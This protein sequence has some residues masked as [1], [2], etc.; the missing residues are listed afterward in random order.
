LAV[1][2]RNLGTVNAWAFIFWCVSSSVWKRLR[3]SD[4]WTCR[5][6]ISCFIY[7]GFDA[8]S[9]KQSSVL[10]VICHSDRPK[11]P[12]PTDFRFIGTKTICPTGYTSLNREEGSFFRAFKPRIVNIDRS[13]RV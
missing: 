5:P 13:S 4:D 7:S 9:K 3:L 6:Y 11:E 12:I 8:S 10:M 1:E 2:D